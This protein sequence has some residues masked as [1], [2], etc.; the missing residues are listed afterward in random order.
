MLLFQRKRQLSPMD[1]SGTNV[2]K[3]MS[4]SL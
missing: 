2:P 3:I 4:A 1:F